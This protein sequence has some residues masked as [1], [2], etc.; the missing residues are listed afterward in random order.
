MM[1]S[2]E[3]FSVW[4]LSIFWV[5]FIGCEKFYMQHNQNDLV[6]C[7]CRN[8]LFTCLHSHSIMEFIPW[9]HCLAWIRLIL[10]SSK[11]KK[12]YEGC[13]SYLKDDVMKWSFIILLQN[14]IG[15]AVFSL[16]SQ[17]YL[18]QENNHYEQNVC[19]VIMVLSLFITHIIS[20]TTLYNSLIH[21][22]SPSYS[23]LEF[24]WCHKLIEI[25]YDD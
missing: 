24:Q 14:V 17:Y 10:R 9:F 21:S 6:A 25:V 8:V 12:N 16:G 23:I 2:S 18:K 13:L 4:S 11:I 1:F 20:F 15:T 7:W 19:I 5:W 22:I 3:L